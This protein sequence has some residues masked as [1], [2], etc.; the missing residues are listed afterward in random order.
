MSLMN[1]ALNL[2]KVLLTRPQQEQER[3]TTTTATV[4]NLSV[5]TWTLRVVPRD[6]GDLSRVMVGERMWGQI[7]VLLEKLSRSR[8]EKCEFVSF[9]S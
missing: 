7:G 1:E 8:P 3:T 5:L 4:F 6:R 9:E 2:A